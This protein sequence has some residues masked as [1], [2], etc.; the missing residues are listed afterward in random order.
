ML[1]PLFTGCIA[2]HQGAMPGEPKAT[3]AQIGDTRVR[4]TDQGEGPAVVLVHGFASSLET[5]TAVVP[6]LLKSHRVLTLDLKGFGWTDRPEGDYSPDAQAKLLWALL[7]ARGVKTAALVGHS[8]GSSVVLAA[9]L[10]VP[11]RVTRI[12]LYD[13]WVYE[14]QL[15]SFF[16]FARQDGLGELM[17]GLYYKQRPDL[18][19]QM[20]FYDKEYVTEALIEDVERSLERPGT[21]AAA[22]A[23]V[24]GQRFAAMQHR[25]RSI[26]KP[27]LILWGREDAVSPL[28]FG[29]RLVSEL[30]KAKLAVF[31]RCGH[32]PMIEAIAASNMAL[33]EFLAEDEEPKPR[34]AP[35]K[36]KAEPKA[37]SKKP[38]DIAPNQ[39]EP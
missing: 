29:E 38:D 30:P 16:H 12:A 33:S 18:K 31:P 4:Y 32:F 7:D 9:A 35:T 10:A 11:E 8:W 36:P 6:E 25:Y 34:P 5:W 23:A 24:R 19:I 17:F 22:L 2:H 28:R 27:T 13:A 20:A 37:D 39:A 14:E 15:P 21:V 26:Q 1:L 3:F